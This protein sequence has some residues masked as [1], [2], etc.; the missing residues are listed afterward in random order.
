MAAQAHNPALA[1]YFQR[2][3]LRWVGWFAILGAGTV[4]YMTGHSV[5]TM[6]FGD[7]Q[8]VRNHWIAYTFV[9]A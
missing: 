2:G 8:K 5:G 6:A 3:Q 9:K 7:A 1:T 4:G